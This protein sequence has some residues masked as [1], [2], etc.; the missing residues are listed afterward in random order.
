L[1]KS[2][3]DPYPQ[4]KRKRSS[5]PQDEDYVPEEELYEYYELNVLINFY[6]SSIFSDPLHSFLTIP[7]DVKVF[8]IYFLHRRKQP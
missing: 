7:L 8:E 4:A 1:Y 6:S 2:P 3:P 5:G